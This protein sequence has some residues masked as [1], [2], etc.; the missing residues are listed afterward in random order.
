MVIVAVDWSGAK[1]RGGARDIALAQAADGRLV[2]IRVGLP[3]TDV[4]RWL[5]RRAAS[6]SSLDRGIYD[7]AWAGAAALVAY[8]AWQPHRGRLD[9]HEVTGW[10][11][12][13]LAVATQALVAS[14]QIY[15][16][17]DE[18]PVSERILTAIV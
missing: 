18:I 8:A 11:A 2:D 14:V 6:T 10:R 9:R 7:A 12:I 16:I 5:L 15:A 3:R 1:A 13:E 4:E 17:F